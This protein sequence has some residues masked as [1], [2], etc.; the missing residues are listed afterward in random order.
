MDTTDI[1][2]LLVSDHND[3]KGAAFLMLEIKH[4][5]KA[6]AWLRE[7]FPWVTHGKDLGGPLRHHLAFTYPGMQ[8][9]GADEFVEYGFAVEFEQGMTTDFRRPTLGDVRANSPENWI[10]GGPNNGGIDLVLMIY[11]T[12]DE[13]LENTL[14]DLL[15]GLEPGGLHLVQ[16]LTSTSNPG[17]KEHFGFK[18]GISQPLLRGFG[19]KGKKENTVAD[20]EMVLGYKN[21][22]KE[23]PESPQVRKGMDPEKFLER[24]ATDKQ[25]LDFGKNGTYMVFRQMRQNVFG[26]WDMVKRSSQEEMVGA[27]TKD[28]IYLASKMF[29]RWPNGTPMTTSPDREDPNEP[30]DS[31]DFLFFKQDPDGKGCPIGSHIRRCNPRDHMPDNYAKSAL[32]IANRHRILR[33]GRTYGPPLHPSYEPELL[34]NTPDDGV[35]R[36]LQFICFNANI[37]LQCEFIQHT[38]CHNTKFFGL[39]NEPDPIIGM[40]DI[41]ENDDPHEFTVPSS[42]IRR[43]YR[44]LRPMVSVIGGAYFF[45]PG[46]KALKYLINYQP[47]NV[48]ICPSSS[49]HSPVS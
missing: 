2:G 12:N 44:N 7:L 25:M 29:G 45:M 22:Y 37:S 27:G 8:K 33:R 5:E 30:G 35:D 31:N 14:S 42:P 13:V 24:S 15:Q 34:A 10:W 23:Y 47:E 3:L 16:H 21:S 36:G 28:A 40:K 11:A 43:R 19:Q 38:W 26:F 41:R 49:D 18:D 46:L 9:L 17:E 20:G 48:Y 4:S 6:R 32:R 1:Q 39:S